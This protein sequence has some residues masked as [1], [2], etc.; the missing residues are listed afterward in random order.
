MD[1]MKENGIKVAGDELIE[2]LL[3]STLTVRVPRQLGHWV[4]VEVDGTTKKITCNCEDYNF[5]RFC[6]HCASF[7][8][9]QFGKNPAMPT[10][11]LARSGEKSGTNALNC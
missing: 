2:R 8:V 5:D 3:D 4:E 9:L 11:R 6:P 10:R 7:E 1:F